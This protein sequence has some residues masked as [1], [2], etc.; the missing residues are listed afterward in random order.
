MEV[1]ERMVERYISLTHPVRRY[2]FMAQIKWVNSQLHDDLVGSEII[3]QVP[4][5]L[6]PSLL[7]SF[8]P[9]LPPF[10]SQSKETPGL[11]LKLF[12]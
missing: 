9:S 5:S 12:S 2:E 6:P 10:F 8:P 7:P 3:I 11:P 1:M 4:P